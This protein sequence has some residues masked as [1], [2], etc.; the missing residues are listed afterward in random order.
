ME[1]EVLPTCSRQGMIWRSVR[2]IPL[3]LLCVSV[4]I[5]ASAAN[6]YLRAGASGTGSGDDWAN[7]YTTLSALESGLSR[8]DVGY[9][10]DGAY[11][12]ATFNT[13]ASGTQT[14]TIKKATIADHGT[15]TGWDNSYGDGQ[16]TFNSTITITTPYW[17]F[18]GVTRNESNWKDT[19]AYGFSI[20][21]NG[22]DTQIRV[23]SHAADHITLKYI[24]LEALNTALPG[25]TI[26]RYTLYV[27]DGDASS[28]FNGWVVQRCFFQ[29][30][31]VP[32]FAR[33][34]QGAIVEYC[35]FADSK[36]NSANHGEPFS[37]YFSC[38][39]GI[40]RYN[41]FTNCA[42]TAILAI[43]VNAD[44][45]EFYG[46]IVQN[47]D[48]SDG[49]VGF[50]GTPPRNVKFYNNTIVGG[51]GFNS[52]VY[53]GDGSVAYNNLFIGNNN[54]YFGG[55]V[56]HDYNG[57]SG[58]SEGEANQVTG[59]TTAI[60]VNYPSDLRLAGATAGGTALGSPYNT[61]LTGETR[62][63]DGTWD[64]G[65]YEFDE[66]GDPPTPDPPTISITGPTSASTYSTAAS[67]VTISGT[68]TDADE[69]T[70]ENQT[71]EANG[72]ATGTDT[73]SAASIA[74]NPGN[75]V[76]VI[77]ATQDGD[78][79]LTAT[80]TITVTRTVPRVLKVGT[81]RIQ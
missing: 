46:N 70:W 35:A 36:S 19:S 71:T 11:G 32:F 54:E 60:F 74:L 51:T 4:A 40:V 57:F 73:W 63:A 43:N 52:G 27:Y 66:G 25:T 62:G 58:G 14:I 26:S 64:R 49:V 72:T 67:T 29:Y 53:L 77:T 45:H 30:G 2:G 47:C 5:P 75:N 1:L 69:V 56:V 55:S 76:I 13:A 21:A 81:L 37:W 59:L 8:G 33:R 48:T 7:A 79:D 24:H 65:A 61:D 9:V 23:S 28:D 17:V 6:K 38:D 22:Q 10:A 44:G 39:N 20:L 18:D 80:D 68:S 41:Y 42:G 12:N 16:A 34:L 15:D 78:P 3:I 31:N 50:I